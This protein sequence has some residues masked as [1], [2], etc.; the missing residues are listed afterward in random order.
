MLFVK[1]NVAIFCFY[2]KQKTI[3]S[4]K[5]KSKKAFNMNKPN[6]RPP[7][8]WPMKR[9]VATCAC[10][11]PGRSVEGPGRNAIENH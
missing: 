1:A 5:L 4:D 6:P 10:T 3:K 2:R 8:N 11:E 7:G 9:Q